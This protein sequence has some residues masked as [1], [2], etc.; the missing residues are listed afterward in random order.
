M[1]FLTYVVLWFGG[2]EVNAVARWVLERFGIA[3]MTV[4]KFVLVVIVILICQTVGLR[5]ESTGRRLAEWAVALTFVPVVF[6]FVLLLVH[7]FA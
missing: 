1:C 3:G 2:A 6:S 5:R 4:F 7:Q